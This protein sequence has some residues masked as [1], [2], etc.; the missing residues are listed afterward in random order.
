VWRAQ[1]SP[2]R[3]RAKEKWAVRVAFVCKSVAVLSAVAAAVVWATFDE[4]RGTLR[5][6]IWVVVLA[7]A[8]LAP[9]FRFFVLKARCARFAMAIRQ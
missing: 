6:A 3:Y 4:K 5:E 1:H 7:T 8:A 9:A 2:D